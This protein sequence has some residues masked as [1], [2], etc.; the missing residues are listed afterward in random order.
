MVLVEYQK[1]LALLGCLFVLTTVVIG[2]VLL[3]PSYLIGHGRLSEVEQKQKDIEQKLAV[4]NAGTTGDIVKDMTEKSIA[5]AP[6]GAKSNTSI[7]IDALN[8]VTIPGI[9]IDHYGYTLNADK[10]LTFDISG[11][12]STRDV[13][14]AFS[15]ALNKSNVFTGANVPLSSLR[16][17]HSVAFT[18]KMGVVGDSRKAPTTNTVATSTTAK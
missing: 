1:R 12:A 16:D 15:D 7:L 9:L 17:Q 11:I 14:L 10:T 5:L 2:S 3:L 8:K 6:L 18:F 4:L 13:L